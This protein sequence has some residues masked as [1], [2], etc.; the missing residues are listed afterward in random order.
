LVLVPA[1]CP[2]QVVNKGGKTLKVA[3]N[4]MNYQSIEA[5]YF[6]ALPLYRSMGK[7]EIY[8]VK[9]I[10]YY[11]LLEKI[12]QVDEGKGGEFI[13]EEF[14]PLLSILEDVIASEW[15]DGDFVGEKDID[16]YRFDDP[17]PHRRVCDFCKC[18]IFN[19]AFHCILCGDDDT[20]YDIC[21]S[22]VAE[23]RGCVHKEKL[24][25]MENI[26][27]NLIKEQFDKAREA[28]QKILKAAKR[29]KKQKKKIEEW[30]SRLKPNEIS[31]GSLSYKLVLVYQNENSEKCHQCEKVQPYSQAVYL[32]CT[33]KSCDQSYCTKC[34][35]NRYGEKLVDMLKKKDWKC[36][37]C[38]S[39]CNCNTCL[40]SRGQNPADLA[41]EKILGDLLDLSTQYPFQNVNSPNV[42]AVSD[43]KPSFQGAKDL[44]FKK[45][46]MLYASGGT[47]S[48]TSSPTTP[49]LNKSPKPVGKMTERQQIKLLMNLTP[50]S[51][52]PV[53]PDVASPKSG[54][55][56][57]TK[58]DNEPTAPKEANSPPTLETHVVPNNDYVSPR[59]EVKSEPVQEVK[60]SVPYSSPPN[61][62]SEP[63][64][65]QSTSEMETSSTS[66]A[67]MDS[68][69]HSGSLQA[70]LL[71][72]SL[73]ANPVDEN[74]K[75]NKYIDH[76]STILVRNLSYGVSPEDLRDLF[77]LC[78]TIENVTIPTDKQT[79]KLKGYGFIKF[80]KRDDAVL[81]MEKYQSYLL[82]DRKIEIEWSVDKT[83]QKKVIHPAKNVLC[84]KCG[85]HGHI[86][87]DCENKP[88]PTSREG[89]EASRSSDDSYRR[90]RERSPSVESVRSSGSSA[91]DYGNMDD[92]NRD[93]KNREVHRGYI[94]FKCGKDGH[95]ANDCKERED[96][97]PGFKGVVCFKCGQ[98]GHLAN[99]CDKKMR[100][101]FVCGKDGHIASEC[102]ERFTAQPVGLV[103]EGEP[104]Q[105]YRRTDSPGSSR[106]AVKDPYERDRDREAERDY[107]RD[108]KYEDRYHDHY[109][110]DRDYR[111]RDRDRDYRDRDRDRGDRDYYRDRYY[112]SRDRDSR[113]GTYTDSNG[114]NSGNTSKSGSVPA[115]FGQTG[116]PSFGAPTEGFSSNQPTTNAT[117]PTPTTPT[118]TQNFSNLLLNPQM[119]GLPN[120]N[121]ASLMSAIPG[122]PQLQQFSNL[123]PQIPNLTTGSLSLDEPRGDDLNE[124][125]RQFKFSV[126]NI[127][128]KQL[129]KYFTPGQIE[130]K[131]DFKFLSKKIVAA[132]VER[133][134]KYVIDKDIEP[135]IKKYVENF[136]QQYSTYKKQNSQ[137]MN[138]GFN[139]MILSCRNF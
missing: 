121:L 45:R 92:R 9:A 100:G 59:M 32:K 63:M 42:A 131:E 6:S 118:A 57:R 50:G 139:Q 99:K 31:P 10:A 124:K 35:W 25:L 123:T 85:G 115:N 39:N 102:T 7:P 130:S 54:K 111:D 68:P 132:L 81:A 79:G 26:S 122:F 71:Q 22:C 72:L 38:R 40:E 46:M 23:G 36:P 28:Y 11:S 137:K 103:K 112:D 56:Q 96:T 116:F 105:K 58:K 119:M 61:V 12:H 97:G 98:A 20:G 16:V 14:P 2:H 107:T 95:V 135:R 93:D 65:S 90:E 77:K 19:R 33:N 127:V 15:V 110:R 129:S 70:Q 78:G 3:W 120:A 73:P 4:T 74:G 82:K 86:A 1:E 109:D 66:S 64:T 114:T 27:M 47:P 138:S 53:L 24:Q 69:E 136:Y 52:I 75:L 126:S 21:Q 41:A 67:Q 76:Y 87:R 62:K 51:E 60:P 88:L 49:K 13:H 55:K 104:P 125:K 34:L 84:Y 91:S 106:E 43:S 108:R 89:R 44:S 117:S 8:R 83:I 37:R 94:C 101:C 133:D 18:D 29:K 80:A 134:T 128:V 30:K 5:S 48:S 17:I 113:Y